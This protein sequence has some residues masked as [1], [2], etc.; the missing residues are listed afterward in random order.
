MTQNEKK[1]D[2]Q[3]EDKT[4]RQTDRR[5]K[6]QIS[7]RSSMQIWSKHYFNEFSIQKAIINHLGINLLEGEL[8]TRDRLAFLN[9]F[10][11][12]KYFFGGV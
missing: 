3:T 2:G 4:D 8:F 12:L 11:V 10:L 1:T 9:G 5:Q 7:M 6:R